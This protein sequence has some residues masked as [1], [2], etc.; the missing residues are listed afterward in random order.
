MYGLNPDR[1][2]K[3][4]DPIRHPYPVSTTPYSKLTG[5]NDFCPYGS[6]RHKG[7]SV[8]PNPDR[9]S[10]LSADI[11]VLAARHNHATHRHRIH[12]DI[13]TTSADVRSPRI[14]L[15]VVKFRSP[16]AR[17]VSAPG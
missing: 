9:N 5:G 13:P 14:L 11:I 16:N 4:Q 17:I 10:N 8:Q 1:W 3:Y 15:G 6:G 2:P 7:A 12:V